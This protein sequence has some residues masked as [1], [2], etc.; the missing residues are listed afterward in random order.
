MSQWKTN[1][2]YSPLKKIKAAFLEQLLH[3]LDVWRHLLLQ[4]HYAIASS[5]QSYEMVT[6]ILQMRKLMYKVQ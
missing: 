6:I 5:W 3:L 1:L 2:G 4:M